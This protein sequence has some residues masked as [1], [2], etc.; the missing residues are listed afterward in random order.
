MIYTGKTKKSSHFCSKLA[1]AFNANVRFTCSRG[2]SPV[3]LGSGAPCESLSSRAVALGSSVYRGQCGKRVATRAVEVAS[4]DPVL[5]WS[6]E[7]IT[8]S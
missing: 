4:D 5:V 8:L 7:I 1:I 6:K 3:Y 2:D